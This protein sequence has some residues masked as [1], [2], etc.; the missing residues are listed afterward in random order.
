MLRVLLLLSAGLM[1][2]PSVSRADAIPVELRR[3]DTGWRLLRGGE[4]F[5]IRGAGGS[6]SLQQLAA[7][8]ANSVR[9]W[10]ADDIDALLDEA[11]AL[12]LSVT[13]GIWLGHERHGFDYNDEIQVRDQLERAR[14]AV[15]RYRDHPALLLWGIGNEMEGFED[16]DDPAIWAAVNDVAAM[17]KELDP[18]H[19]TMTVTADIGGGRIDSVDEARPGHRHSRH[20]LLRGRPVAARA[21]PGRRRIQAL[22]ADRIRASRDV[23]D[24]ED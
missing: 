7:A 17:V 1:L 21:L 23:G 3:T 18:A 10:G 14:A 11:H 12:G 24:C 13:V 15:L 2:M 6:G 8:G 20:Q 4:P 22:R 5:F 19:P 16:G 9:T